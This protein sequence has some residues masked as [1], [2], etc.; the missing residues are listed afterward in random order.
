MLSVLFRETENRCSQFISPVLF[1]ELHFLWPPHAIVSVLLSITVPLGL[2]T[3]TR[4][5]QKDARTRRNFMENRKDQSIL[6]RT[7]KLLNKEI[8]DRRMMDR[9]FETQRV[10]RLAPS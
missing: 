7:V 1:V 2:I 4:R 5:S 10:E 8:P 9:T 3:R 6:G